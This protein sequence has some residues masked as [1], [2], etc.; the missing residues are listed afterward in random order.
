MRKAFITVAPNMDDENYAL[1]VEGI[2]AQFGE[3]Q[4]IKTVDASLLGGFVLKTDGTV[5]DYSASAKLAN[6]KKFIKE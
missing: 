5:Y 2:C 4:F 1:L 6:L 3:M